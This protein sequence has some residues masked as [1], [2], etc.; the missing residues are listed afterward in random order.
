MHAALSGKMTMKRKTS[1]QETAVRVCYFCGSTQ[2]Q[3]L[4][5][6]CA[7][8]I[9]VEVSGNELKVGARL[10]VAF[11]Q[12]HAQRAA[13]I[14]AVQLAVKKGTATID[15]SPEFSDAG[16]NVVSFYDRTVLLKAGQS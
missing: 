12:L 9:V 10:H 16:E 1:E 14:S 7:H 13:F 3:E 11:Q 15:R 8:G 4:L 2:P 5:P 6:Q